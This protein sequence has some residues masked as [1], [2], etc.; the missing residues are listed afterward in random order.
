MAMLVQLGRVVLRQGFDAWIDVAASP[1]TVTVVDATPAIAKELIQIPSSFPKDPAD[2]L[3]VATARALDLPLL[4][5]D[6][7]IR[8]SRLV[9]LWKA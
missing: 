6:R 8:R 3:I 2:R 9:R 4:T 1:G 7:A 5:Y